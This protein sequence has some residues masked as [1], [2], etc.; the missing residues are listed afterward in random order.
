[1]DSIT[2][3]Y[4]KIAFQYDQI[5]FGNSYGQYVDTLERTVLSSI[6]YDSNPTENLEIACGTGRLFHYAQTGVDISKNMLRVT[7][8]K[9]PNAHLV[10]ASFDSIPLETGLFSNIYA[11]HLLMHLNESKIEGFSKEAMRLLK[12]DGRLIVDVPSLFRRRF[13]PSRRHW[14]GSY[15]PSLATFEDLGWTIERVHPI[16]FL[17]IH[18]VPKKLR[19][20][21]LVM[22]TLLSSFLP[23]HYASYMILEMRKRV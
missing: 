9:Y 12:D 22:E 10:N 19:K 5:R 11:F 18:R 17:P 1:M 3:Y 13:K 15:A 6:L 8:E 4:E 14:H 23:T 2:L 21:C 7:R 20:S 16:M